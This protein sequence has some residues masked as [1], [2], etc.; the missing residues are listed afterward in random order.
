MA[1]DVKGFARFVVLALLLVELRQTSATDGVVIRDQRQE[2]GARRSEFLPFDLLHRIG[3]DKQIGKL[4]LRQLKIEPRSRFPCPG[5][6]WTSCDARN[7]RPGI[8]NES[9]HQFQWPSTEALYCW[10]SSFD[11]ASSRKFV[12]GPCN[13]CAENKRPESS[14]RGNGAISNVPTWSRLL[15]C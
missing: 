11:W 7:D 2:G 14:K 13:A 1:L 4:E 6:G 9:P 3:Q 8:G 10:S 15:R 5:R 12:G